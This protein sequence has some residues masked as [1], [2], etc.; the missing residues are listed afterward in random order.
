M[1][2]ILTHA[3]TIHESLHTIQ[4]HNLVEGNSRCWT[5]TGLSHRICI[6]NPNT[7]A[8][9]WTRKLGVDDGDRFGRLCP[10]V[11]TMARTE[12]EPAG[13]V[14]A[15]K[16]RGPFVEGWRWMSL[17]LVALIF[18]FSHFVTAI[19]DFPVNV[20][21]QNTHLHAQWLPWDFSTHH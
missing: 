9:G 18:T 17:L 4:E 12:K 5:V 15:L 10:F 6:W 14:A 7:V 21:E 11:L 20:M 13:F 16:C 3:S 19:I 8:W 1:T 2:T